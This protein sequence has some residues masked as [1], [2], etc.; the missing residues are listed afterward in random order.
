M[1]KKDEIIEITASDGSISKCELFDMVELN[2][3]YYALLVEE[4]HAEDDEPE[5]IIMRYREVGDD[6]FFEEI[7]DENEFQE[8]SQLVENLPNSQE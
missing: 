3:K 5:L 1:T 8:I 6:V 4:N 2:N 7:T